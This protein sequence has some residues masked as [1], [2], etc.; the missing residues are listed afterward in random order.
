[1]TVSISLGD[2]GLLEYLSDPGL[3]LVCGICLEN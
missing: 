1:M 2:M 3:T